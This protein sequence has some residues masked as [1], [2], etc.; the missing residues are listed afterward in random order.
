MDLLARI[1][2][3]FTELNFKEVHVNRQKLYEY[4]GHYYFVSFVKGLNS[5]V[6]ESAENLSEA[7][8]NMFEDSGVYPLT[9]GENEL[10][11]VIRADLIQF[12]IN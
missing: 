7:E 2:S 4:N 10:L 3:I 8:T 11:R 5:Y 9:L 1:E 6:I 12:Y